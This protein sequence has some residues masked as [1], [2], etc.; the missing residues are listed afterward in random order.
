VYDPKRHGISRGYLHLRDLVWDTTNQATNSPILD[1]ILPVIRFTFP[2][3]NS[4]SNSHPAQPIFIR[5]ARELD[6]WLEWARSIFLR[7]RSSAA[8]VFS[9]RASKVRFS[10]FTIL[11]TPVWL[12]SS[13][14]PRGPRLVRVDVSSTVLPSTSYYSH[15]MSACLPPSEMRKVHF[16]LYYSNAQ[17]LPSS[18]IPLRVAPSTL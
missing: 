17:W 2:F 1:N 11:L 4:S 15:R 8:A 3:P 18:C 6:I 14:S 7:S 16:T 13:S 5:P 9:H 10:G 12:Y